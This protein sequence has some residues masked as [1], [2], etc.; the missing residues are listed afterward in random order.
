MYS[1]QLYVIKFF[2]DL[3]Q[4]SG[5]L[6]VFQIPPRYNWNIV[7]SGIKHHNTNPVLWFSWNITHLALNNNHSLT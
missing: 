7:E 2:S 6:W 4:V 1:I 5:F 3:Q